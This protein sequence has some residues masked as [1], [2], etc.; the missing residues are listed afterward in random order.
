MSPCCA[1]ARGKNALI[2]AF[3]EYLSDSFRPLLPVLLGASLILAALAVLEAFGVV[4]THAKVIPSWLGFTNSMWRAVFY[5]LP[6]MVAYNA[7]KKLDIDPWVGTAVILAL[8]TPDFLGL[9]IAVHDGRKHVPVFVT[10]SMVGHK[11]GEFAPTRTFR[12]HDK[13]DRKGRRR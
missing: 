5:F 11:L 3:F 9:T 13:D 2:D 7:S 4:D 10:E 12:S 1:K 8:L 6:A